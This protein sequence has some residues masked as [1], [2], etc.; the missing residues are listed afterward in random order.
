MCIHEMVLLFSI[1][2]EGHIFKIHFRTNTGAAQSLKKK[3][4]HIFLFPF[5]GS[6]ELTE[7]FSLQIRKITYF[8]I[9]LFGKERLEI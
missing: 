6:R 8:C 7:L 4:Y 9:H 5:A 3:E 2:P 1:Q